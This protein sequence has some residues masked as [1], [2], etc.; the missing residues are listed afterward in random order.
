MAPISLAIL[1]PI[2][3]ILLEI[4]KQKINR[5][6]V[7][8]ISQDVKD[9]MNKFKMLLQIITGIVLNPVLIM[10]VLGIIGNIIFKHNLSVYIEG[11]LEVTFLLIFFK[12]IYETVFSMF[13]GINFNKNNF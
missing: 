1:N 8:E 6:N 12:L 3:F 4:N 5:Q 9:Y 7:S 13:G 2:A 11:L 10:T